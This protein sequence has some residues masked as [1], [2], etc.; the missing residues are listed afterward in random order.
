[1]KHTLRTAAFILTVS[2]VSVSLAAIP[3]S[4]NFDGLTI[5]SD[6]IPAQ[7]NWG[8]DVADIV[9]ST[10]NAQSGANSVDI[11]GGTISNN[12]D[13]ASPAGVVWT[14]F[15]LIPNLGAEPGSVSATDNHVHYYDTNGNIN[16][17]VSGAF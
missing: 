15:Y 1:M 10:A 2:L 14:E 4:E 11:N 8:A 9:V 3:T 6:F 5:G 13:E 17:Y 16:V 12:V 7:N